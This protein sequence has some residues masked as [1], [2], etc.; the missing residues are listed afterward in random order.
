[1]ITEIVLMWIAL[2]CYAVSSALYAVNVVFGSKW[3]A[4]GALIA[5]MLGLVSHTAAIIV[6][7]VAVGHGPYLGFY[8]VVSSLAWCT[9]VALVVIAWR[10]PG[11]QQIGV[12]IMPL[13][14]LSVGAAML[15]PK[16]Q[17]EITGTL[18]SWWLVLHVGFAKLTYGAFIVSFALAL[19]FLIREHSTELPRWARFL[20]KMPSQQV[21][22]DLSFK[23]IAV[24]FI[25][26]AI[27][28]AAGAIWANEAWGRYWS[29][30]P[31]ET[32][33]L[34]SWLIYAAYLHLRLTMGWRGT[35]TAWIAVL[36]L[37]VL[38]FAFLGVP[39]VY[40]SIHA[41]YLTGT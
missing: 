4:R 14:L 22:D 10:R 31:I 7:W 11:L 41:A 23:F 2:T 17:M 9:V 12:V 38:V 25:L 29:W 40:N 19:V 8:E 24:G 20:E 37:P 27:M 33:S 28:I 6:R 32:W 30:D 13:A 34:I 5:A 16:S 21:I 36:A 15:A 3:S 39:L 26:L 1:M 18:A 35:K